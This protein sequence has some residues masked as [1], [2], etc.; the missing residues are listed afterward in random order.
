[1]DPKMRETY[2]RCVREVARGLEVDL[3][4]INYIV[5]VIKFEQLQW[6]RRC[7]AI[8]RLLE[9]LDCLPTS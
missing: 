8:T 4:D 1:M 3:S 9:Y 2:S 7:G 6:D 5:R